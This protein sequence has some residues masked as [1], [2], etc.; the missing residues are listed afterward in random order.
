MV[1][2]H[3]DT[4]NMDEESFHDSDPSPIQLVIKT[5]SGEY[6]LET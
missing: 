2:R 5:S 4:S 3:H 6:F 1:V